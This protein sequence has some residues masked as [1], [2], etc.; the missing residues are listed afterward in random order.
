LD[1][2]ARSQKLFLL[3][4]LFLPVLSLAA[5][6]PRGP[7]VGGVAISPEL[8]RTLYDRIAPLRESDG[9]L[10][11]RF[12]TAHTRITLV[13]YAPSGAEHSLSLTAPLRRS[14]GGWAVTPSPELERDCG[15]TLTA[16]ERVLAKTPVQRFRTLLFSLDNYTLLVVQFVV[17]VVGTLYILYRE[18]RTRRPSPYAVMALL[19]TWGAALVLRL[20][21]SPRTFLHE[22][23]HIAETI[24]GYL[25]S[26]MAPAYGRVGPALYRF[27]GGVLE[28]PDDVQ[29]IFVTNAVLASL[30][31]PAVALFDLALMRSWPRA[32]C[33]AVLLCVLPQHLRF[34]A[35]EDLFIL[36]VSFG[37]WALALF[38]L[39][40]RTRRL[41]E[42]LCAAL[43]L[44]LGM[45]TR[46]EMAVFP[47]LLVA[48][49]LL[50]EPRSWRLLF[51][52]RTVVAATLAAVL[53]TPRFLELLE[54]MSAGGPSID[55]LPDL[56]RY[57]QSLVFFQERVTPQAYWVLA[58]IGL[59]C[60]LRRIP[61]LCLWVL[62]VFFGYTLFSF[63]MFGNPQYTLRAQ[64][65]PTSFVVLIAAGAAPLWVDLWGAARRTV[66]L[67]I[68]AVALVTLGSAVVYATKGFVTE[69]R[70][71]QLEWAFLERSVAR[72]P[73]RGT[74]LTRVEVG[75]FRLNVFPQFLLRRDGK[76]YEMVD[77]GRAAAGDVP[78][79]AP[80]EEL[81]FYQGMFCHFTVAPGE[82]APDPLSPECAAVYER[83][84][85][86]P[87]LVED[88]DTEGY[89]LMPYA[90]GPF[91]IGFFRLEA[92]R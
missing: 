34:S 80:S 65:L 89:S 43:A 22:Y 56:V 27:V 29:V 61:G 16:I 30:A 58:A 75:G 78:W 19:L 45:Q 41:E 36:A 68:G 46:P 31:I 18:L 50:V 87:L 51:A 62:L 86:E 92:A 21:V 32:I 35:A 1:S 53:L 72:L 84:V 88:L 9:C 90:P 10:L 67:G 39:Y 6:P 74:L 23:Y 82:P 17:L 47:V 73:P 24:T 38:A 70:D 8:A 69:L 37:L 54:A 20:M 55:G 5:D 2:R 42:A 81:I 59:V 48:L 26:E 57:R 14:M 85:A 25:N 91:R 28:R 76:S 3:T 12:D 40:L 33:A 77:V 11:S 64:L 66:A 49:V 83:Y 71:Q 15:A 4:L 13:L 7:A 63:S 52:G 79:P 44:S 60:G